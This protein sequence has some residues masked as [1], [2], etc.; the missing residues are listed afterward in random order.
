L[1][2]TGGIIKGEKTGDYLY[3]A[4]VYQPQSGTPAL[5]AVSMLSKNNSTVTIQHMLAT[6]VENYGKVKGKKLFPKMIV[7]DHSFANIHA[8]LRAFKLWDLTSYLHDVWGL[9]RRHGRSDLSR[10]CLRNFQKINPMNSNSIYW[11][12]SEESHETG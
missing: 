2:S 1:D 10:R 9:V 6:L 3:H 11:R 4:V 7:P 12:R 5:P 8:I